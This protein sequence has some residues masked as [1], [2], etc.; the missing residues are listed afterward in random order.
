MNHNYYN[1]FIEVADDCSAP[2]AEVPP[3][4]GDKATV[5]V[6]HF[7][8]IAEHPYAYTQED[9]LF[10]TYARTHAIP[11]SEREAERAKFFSKGQPCLRTSPLCKRYGWGFHHDAEGRVALYPRGSAEYEQF[12]SA[13]EVK[14]LKGMRSKRA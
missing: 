8:L 11:D 7:E 13:D 12:A 9:I 6:I 14:H 5:A 2:L 4:K 1:T 3:L 10:E